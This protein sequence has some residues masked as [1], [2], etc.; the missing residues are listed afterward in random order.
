MPRETVSEIAE[1]ILSYLN[2]HPD[3]SDTLEGIVKWWLMQQKIELAKA[4]VEKALELLVSKHL[5]HKHIYPDGS[6][7]YSIMKK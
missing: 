7:H 5:A 6:I 2:S 4:D 1:Q 3:A